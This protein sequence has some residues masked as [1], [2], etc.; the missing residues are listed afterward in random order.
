MASI[1]VVTVT[2]NSGAV[3]T[4]FLECVNA[5]SHDDF[6]LIVIDNASWDQSLQIVEAHAPASTL[7][8]P[9]AE[10]IGVGAANNL[11]IRAALE[12]GSNYV[13]FLNND[14]AFG[15]DLFKILEQSARECGVSMVAPK[16]VYHDQRNLIWAAGGRFIMPPVYLHQHRG[17]NARDH[18][19]FDARALVSYA[20]TCCLLVGKGVFERVGVMDPDYFVYFDDV[21]F[22]FRAWRAGFVVL[23]EPT[24]VVLHKVSALTGGR[25]SLY[26]AKMSTRNRIYFQRKHLTRFGR[27][28]WRLLFEMKQLQRFALRLEDRQIRRAR[29]SA[30]KEGARMVTP[31]Q[32]SRAHEVAVPEYPHTP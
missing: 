7:V 20:P 6:G 16:I 14:T 26:Y 27:W 21:D 11:G 12:Q 9:N 8:I 4:E 28:A 30:L 19:Q 31:A 32:F 17:F 24:G 10:N 25:Q 2:Y 29:R 23:Y 3:L 15:P 18:G 13:L 1:S 22:S 5:Q